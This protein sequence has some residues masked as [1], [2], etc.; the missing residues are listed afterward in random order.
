MSYVLELLYDM[1]VKPKAAFKVI[2]WEEK[3]AKACQIVLFSTVFSSLA[4]SAGIFEGTFKGIILL[5][6]IVCSVLTWGICAAV[7]HLLAELLGGQGSVKKLLTAIGFTYFLQLLIIPIYLIASFLPTFGFLIILLATLIITV[8][9]VVLGI[10]AIR[11]VY[12]FS[13]GR[14]SFVY[15]LP[16]LVMGAL[17]LIL[18]FSASAFF[19]SA[20][21]DILTN[22][23]QF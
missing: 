10:L 11:E 21:S 5:A 8:W 4:A 7:W 18:F 16:V 20:A 12:Q 1:L 13:G 9:S 17:V 19:M 6:Q 22:P 2:V 3:V 14:A 15:F 23:P